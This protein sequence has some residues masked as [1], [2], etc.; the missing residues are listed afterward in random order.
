MTTGTEFT[1]TSP[2]ASSAAPA[3]V[4]LA[5]GTIKLWREQRLRRQGEDR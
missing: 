5:V 1:D 2:V 4:T 3:L